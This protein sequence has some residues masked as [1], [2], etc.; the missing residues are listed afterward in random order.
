[1]TI[2]L[3]FAMIEACDALAATR[4]HRQPQGR[5]DPEPAR[6]VGGGNE[7]GQPVPLLRRHQR[8]HYE[9]REHSSGQF[10]QNE[11]HHQA[12]DRGEDGKTAHCRGSSPIVLMG[13]FSGATGDLAAARPGA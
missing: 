7:L 3:P 2:G 8:H 9:D 10:G 12:A 6:A 13:R 11:E 4:H 1:V 5:P